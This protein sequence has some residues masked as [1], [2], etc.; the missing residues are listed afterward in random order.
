MATA[1]TV[2]SSV[3]PAFSLSGDYLLTGSFTLSGTQY[4]CSV[5]IQVRAPG[6][7]A[8]GCWTPCR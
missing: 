7:R 6:I 1:P 8:E 2:T 4:T 5:K 3:Y